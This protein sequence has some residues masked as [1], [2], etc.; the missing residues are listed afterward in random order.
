[1]IYEG[2]KS[3]TEMNENGCRKEAG[4]NTYAG[5]SYKSKK[6]EKGMII[7]RLTLAFISANK[8]A[9][10]LSEIDRTSQ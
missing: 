9:N 7:I 1:M 2:I 8:I 10:Q 5:S 6:N 3:V 4:T